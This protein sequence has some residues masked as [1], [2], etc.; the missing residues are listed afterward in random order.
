MQG[1]ANEPHSVI[2]AQVAELFDLLKTALSG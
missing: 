2:T 1:S